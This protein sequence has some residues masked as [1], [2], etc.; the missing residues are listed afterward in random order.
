MVLVWPWRFE[1]IDHNTLPALIDLR[2]DLA[3][4]NLQTEG[5]I[6]YPKNQ[7]TDG[8]ISFHLEFYQYRIDQVTMD[9]W[10]CIIQVWKPFLIQ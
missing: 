8:S 7:K 9:F 2:L 5:F 1:I 6:L 10:Q 4:P 3:A